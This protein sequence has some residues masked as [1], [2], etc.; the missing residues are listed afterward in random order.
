MYS[1][2]GRHGV[3]GVIRVNPM[4]SLVC[5]SL[6]PKPF[7]MNTEIVISQVTCSLHHPG[8]T[9]QPDGRYK[10]TAPPSLPF[11]HNGVLVSLNYDSFQLTFEDRN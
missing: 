2:R 9:K 3:V 11:S 1:G 10:D 6:A 7:P 8:V 4:L 5:L